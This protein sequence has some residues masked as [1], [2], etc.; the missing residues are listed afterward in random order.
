MVSHLNPQVLTVDYEK[1]YIGGLFE[2]EIGERG[3]QESNYYF[4]CCGSPNDSGGS[5][6]GIYK[7]QL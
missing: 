6:N 1:I 4:D 3:S 2:N 5:R 7:N